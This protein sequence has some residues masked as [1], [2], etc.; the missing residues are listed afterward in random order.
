[1]RLPGTP[2]QLLRGYPPCSSVCTRAGT[3]PAS[4]AGFPRGAEVA[5]AHST[6]LP[7]QLPWGSTPCSSTWAGSSQA[8]LAGFLLAL[9][10]SPAAPRWCLRARPGPPFLNLFLPRGLPS[11]PHMCTQIWRSLASPRRGSP[12][13]HGHCCGGGSMAAQGP[14]LRAGPPYVAQTRHTPHICLGKKSDTTIG[15]SV[16]T[17]LKKPKHLEGIM[18]TAIL[19][20]SR[21]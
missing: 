8:G 17:F 13:I 1:M 9:P 5:L 20:A 14:P 2:L 21:K 4:L 10:V 3:S 18:G 11:A 16:A 12:A 15:D 7:L 19:K 6:R